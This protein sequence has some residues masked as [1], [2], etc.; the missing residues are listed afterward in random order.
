MR[1]CLR[2]VVASAAFLLRLS[3][4]VFLIRLVIQLCCQLG[5]APAVE[6]FLGLYGIHLAARVPLLF[7]RRLFTVDHDVHQVGL[8]LGIA[9]LFIVDWSVSLL[10]LAL[11]ALRIVFHI[12]RGALLLSFDAHSDQLD[13]LRA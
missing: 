4:V 7:A 5:C 6:S 3:L 9:G 8:D 1:L 2:R 10:D 13:R 12:L 11:D